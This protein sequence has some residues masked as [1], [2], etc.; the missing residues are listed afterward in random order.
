MTRETRHNVH[1]DLPLSSSLTPRLQWMPEVGSTNAELVQQLTVAD[2]GRW[3]HFSV[4]ASDNQTRG[5]GR[6]GRD[7]SAPAGASLA[8]S[9]VIRPTT[10]SGRP[11][12]TEALGW[13][14]LLAGLAMSRV[15]SSVLP[16]GV[17]A[18]V[19]WPNDV[20]IGQR[21]VCG[22]LSE[23]VMTPQGLAVV[24]GAGVNLSLDTDQ[25]PVPTA[26]SLVLGGVEAPDVDTILAAYLTEF[27]RIVGVFLASEGDAVS[28]GLR[29]DVQ[30]ACDTVGRSVRIEMPAGD[31]LV[32]TA[33]RITDAGAIE[34]KLSDGIT[35]VEVAA[36]DVTHLR[37]I[38]D[39]A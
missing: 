33:T 5:K 24:V 8:I 26:T 36:G 29:D 12:K 1:M 18:S 2:P 20:L 6:L 27:S 19:K 17:L 25:L 32:G 4:V 30:R 37:V 11:L 9:V 39:G 35:T 22:V 34:V 10:P 15:C 38:M 16:T 7:W 23:L 13:L 28:S 3:P 21:K 14:G 31:H